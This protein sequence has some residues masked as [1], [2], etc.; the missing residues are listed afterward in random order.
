[1][2]ISTIQKTAKKLR[3]KGIVRYS[4]ENLIKAIQRQEGNF[5]CFGTAISDCDQI[6][7]SWRKDCLKIK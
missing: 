2:R 5:E 7:C 3:I 6:N 4:K 1:M